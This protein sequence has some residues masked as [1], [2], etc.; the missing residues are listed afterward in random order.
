MIGADA[1]SA[2]GGL[3]A[4]GP[5]GRNLRGSHGSPF[6]AMA[7]AQIASNSGRSRHSLVNLAALLRSRL[8]C[9]WRFC[10]G[11]QPRRLQF[12]PG[13]PRNRPL[14]VWQCW[15]GSLRGRRPC[16]TFHRS[17]VAFCWWVQTLA[18]NDGKACSLAASLRW[19][20]RTERIGVL[21][22]HAAL[23]V[24]LGYGPTVSKLLGD[25]AIV[26]AMPEGAAALVKGGP[27]CRRTSNCSGFAI[28]CFAT[29]TPSQTQRKCRQLRRQTTAVRRR[30]VRA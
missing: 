25:P 2:L 3:T 27:A 9:A 4:S 22:A 17:N 14:G 19:K 29:N 12:Y 7:C 6:T 21:L 24:R 16:S 10:R 1:G 8:L 13:S 28:Q 15:P 30:G 5:L 18:R 11:S 23:A 26:P 20:R